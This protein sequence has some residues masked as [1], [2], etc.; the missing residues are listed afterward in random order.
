MYNKVPLWQEVKEVIGKGAVMSIMFNQGGETSHRQAWT[1]RTCPMARHAKC[2]EVR[3]VFADAAKKCARLDRARC[4][5]V[6]H[7]PQAALGN[8]SR[9]RLRK[10]TMTMEC[11]AGVWGVV[12][13][14]LIQH[15]WGRY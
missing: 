2:L 8:S 7:R 5:G 15:T 1:H 12:G 14:F 6:T 11:L 9:V 4:D 10:A 13:Q 3:K